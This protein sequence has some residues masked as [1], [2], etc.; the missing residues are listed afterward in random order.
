MKAALDRTPS[1]GEVV[2]RVG[3]AIGFYSESELDEITSLSRVT[4]WRL[5]KLGKFPP[6]VELSPGRRGT[7]KAAVHEWI[8]SKL[9]TGQRD[10]AP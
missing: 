6:S 8:E 4:R 2:A 9:E 3:I 7:P 1:V 10:V 5:T